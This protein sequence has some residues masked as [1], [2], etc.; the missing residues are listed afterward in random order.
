MKST[1]LSVA[2]EIANEVTLVYYVFIN[3]KISSA[4]ICSEKHTADLLV[5]CYVS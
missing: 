1:V 2:D 3:A 5:M 4:L